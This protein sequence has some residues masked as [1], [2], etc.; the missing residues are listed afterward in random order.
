MTQDKLC[1]VPSYIGGGGGKQVPA[2]KM[3]T[4]LFHYKKQ[5][6]CAVCAVC[7]VVLLHVETHCSV[8]TADDSAPQTDTSKSCTNFRADTNQGQS[9]V[10]VYLLVTIVNSSTN[11]FLLTFY[12]FS[13][14]LLSLTFISRDCPITTLTPKLPFSSKYYRLTS[15]SLVYTA[16]GSN[17]RQKQ[18]AK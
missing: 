7:L 11:N 5:V 2:R 3:K 15:F 18:D 1:Q 9:L 4:K 16:Q 12:T 17:E 13:P 14:P 8:R 6:I 10:S